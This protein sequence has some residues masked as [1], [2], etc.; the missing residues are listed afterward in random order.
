MF[1]V[2]T[3]E[4]VNYPPVCVKNYHQFTSQLN[5][6]V[7]TDERSCSS[8]TGFSVIP[9]TQRKDEFHAPVPTDEGSSSTC[10]IQSSFASSNPVQDR[11]AT[12]GD[13]HIIDDFS[14]QPITRENVL[15]FSKCSHNDDSYVPP[16][17]IT[18]ECSSSSCLGI[19]GSNSV[20]VSN[21]GRTMY[22]PSGSDLSQNIDGR[23]LLSDILSFCKPVTVSQDV[24]ARINNML[25]TRWPVVS[26]EAKTDIPHFAHLYEQ[27][28]SYNLPNCIG[29]KIPINSG[30]KVERWVV[31][32][33]EYHD[34]EL[35]HFLAYGWPIGF[36]AEDLPQTV[37]DNHPSAIEF[38]DHVKNFLAT[39]LQFQA[40]EG[41]LQAPPFKP[42][43]RISPLMTRP[44]KGST[45][46]R[47]I[48][49][50]SYPDGAA[51]NTGIDT[52][53]YLGKDIS[54]TLPSISDLIAKLQVE[55][56]G[57]FIWKA[58]LARA[59][60][61][62]R[63]DPVDAPLLCIQFGG[64]VYIDKCPP[65]G[66]RSSSAA[67][68]RVANALVYLLA[69]NNHH[70]LAY[71]DDFAGCSSHLERAHQAFTCFK[72]LASYLG[73]QLAPHKCLEPAT[74]VEWL[75]Y[76]ID[77]ENMTISIPQDKLQEVVEECGTWLN[78]K[79]VT[80]TMVQSLVGRLSHVANC[81][82]PGRKFLARMLGTLRAFKNKKWTTID[83]EFIKDVRWF[84]HYATSS[85][86]I[87]LY[88]PT[89][90]TVIIECDASLQGA[91]GNTTTHCYTWC[92]SLQYEHQYPVIH[93]LEAINTLVAYRTLAHCTVKGPIRALILTDNMS[94][95]QAL[96][97][98]RTKDTVLASC[99]REF[100]LEAAK[101]GDGIDIEHRPGVE[102]PLAD[103]L[104]RMA[105]DSTKSDY[106]HTVVAQE[107]MCFI[108]PILNNYVF[109]DP[110]I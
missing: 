95:S 105:T 89:L 50:L 71:L 62:L 48:V 106:V 109:F 4:D 61:Q 34:N 101:N 92:Y 68:Q 9:P 13:A 97:S 39:E 52:T 17:V 19:Q 94:S 29:A 35:C 47:V 54:Y 2:A 20:M 87:T 78:K 98:G 21:R 108:D 103:A 24:L 110:S 15:C 59:Y 45:Q 28:K 64:Q 27:V 81:V 36:Y 33:Q 16:P 77:T 37:P 10:S 40:I 91:G 90:P 31:L 56:K 25:A 55:G 76:C 57:A 6:P 30:L 14:Y 65:F 41:P 43:S 1:Q 72:N 42:W 51:V 26:E 67:C 88:S 60:R 80:K 53:N 70:C 12:H 99:A 11:V 96:M 66:C 73:L 75:G 79:R 3:R 46:R 102:I 22:C 5:A 18:D 93:Q 82:T 100:W 44:K 69:K 74:Q 49:D 23:A 7:Y 107:K 8:H 58:D 63:A 85:N 84:Y 83:E 104:S 32:L 86:G 38:P